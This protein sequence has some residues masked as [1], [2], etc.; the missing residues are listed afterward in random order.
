MFPAMRAI[1][2]S[3]MGGLVFVAL[4]LWFVFDD[5]AETPDLSWV[6][7]VLALGAAAA[8][9][10]NTVGFRA[11]A[12]SP[13]ATTE[14]SA[15][16][17]RAAFQTG[18]ISRMAMAEM[19]AIAAIALA[20]VARDGGYVLYLLGAVISLTLLAVYALPSDGAVARTQR[21]LEREGGRADVASA[22]GR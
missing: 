17:A 15:Q 2:T 16:Q 20:F 18:T 6:G 4:A 10:I 13:A 1:V 19:P 14:E 3:V 22:L 5:R 8:G 9:L 21:S 12:V 7:I 11:P